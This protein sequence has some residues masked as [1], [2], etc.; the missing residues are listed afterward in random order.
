MT[1]LSLS[2]A[3]EMNVN[4]KGLIP[5]F[6]FLFFLGVYS[7]TSS[8]NV[9]G[10]VDGT[11]RYAVTKSIVDSGSV[12]I[13]EDLGRYM[14]VTGTNG[15]YYSWY[16][17]GQSALMTPFYVIG[18]AVGMPEFIVSLFNPLISAI[19][20]VVVFLFCVRLGYCNRTAVIVTLMYGLGTIAWPQSKGPFEHPLETALIMLS[21]F[22]IH[23]HVGNKSNLKLILSAVLLGI[24][25]ITRVPTLLT[26]FPVLLYLLF[27]HIRGKTLISFFKEAIIY[28]ITLVPFGIFFLCYNYVRFGDVFETGYSKSLNHLGIDTFGTPLHVGLYGL[29]LSPGKGFLLYSPIVILFILAL[30]NF[31]KKNKGLTIAFLTLITAYLLFHSKYYAWHGDWAWGPRRLTVL[32]PFLMIPLAELFEGGM[33]KRFIHV[34]ILA[35]SLLAIS[36]SI[37]IA[38]V[39]VN[40]NKYFIENQLPSRN[41][42]THIYFDPRYS[43]IK[44]QFKF[45]VEIAK[46][47]RYYTPPEIQT[48][49]NDAK[50]INEQITLN[51]PDFWFVYYIYAGAPKR[52][53]VGMLI[54][55]LALTA[56]SLT[57]IL[58]HTFYEKP[59]PLPNFT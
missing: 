30:K 22:L 24:A 3:K 39:T 26:I 34:K 54:I 28:G 1:S 21:I 23:L 47:I 44:E 2:K 8:G 20:C 10:T 42:P 9:H 32:T 45:I 13:P 35:I 48:D 29:I 17:I 25:F 59:L 16:G 19:T 6:I 57:M 46:K 7:L 51:V 12:S 56:F 55:P 38:A 36:I 41:L 37:Q 15:N 40:L 27:S 58:R 43:P 52:L 31:Y 5:I 33:L 50:A 14:G 4:N 11:V 49:T 53:V 18:K